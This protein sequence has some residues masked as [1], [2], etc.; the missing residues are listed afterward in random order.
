MEFLEMHN[1]GSYSPGVLE[2]VNPASEELGAVDSMF[3]IDDR[4]SLR[5]TRRNEAIT[6]TAKNWT[7]E[8]AVTSVKNQGACGSCWAF[9]AVGALEGMTFL[10]TQNLTDLSVQE[11]VDCDK[12]DRGCFGGL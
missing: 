6:P 7:N 2:F 12:S 1:L 10:R 4:M 11:F 3:E 9:S 8:G 5:G